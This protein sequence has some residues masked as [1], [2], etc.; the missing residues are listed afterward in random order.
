MASLESEFDA[1][2]DTIH[3]MHFEGRD[4]SISSQPFIKH[5]TVNSWLES[6]VFGL[7]MARSKPA[8][9]VMAMA[10]RAMSSDH[11]DVAEIERINEHLVEA[12]PEDDPFW[13]RW[14]RFAEFN[15]ERHR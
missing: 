5:G 4:V 12:L 11:I 10:R 7:S 14:N 9:D 1:E 13:V 15:R 6:D 8:E 3:V 2:N